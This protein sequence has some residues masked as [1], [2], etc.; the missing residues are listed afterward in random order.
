MFTGPDEVKGL[1]GFVKALYIASEKIETSSLN[2]RKVGFRNGLASLCNV[3]VFALWQL[4]CGGVAR[5]IL[6]LTGF[7]VLA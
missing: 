3:P 5:S 2:L 1:L 6:G 4:L 7:R